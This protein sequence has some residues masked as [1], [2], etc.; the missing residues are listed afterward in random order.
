MAIDAVT[1]YLFQF[2]E[3]SN[4]I[5][6]RYFGKTRPQIRFDFHVPEFISDIARSMDLSGGEKSVPVRAKMQILTIM[7]SIHNFISGEDF[8]RPMLGLEKDAYRAR[9]KETLKSI[10]IPAFNGA[11]RRDE[12]LNESKDLGNT[13]RSPIFPGGFGAWM[14]NLDIP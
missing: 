9:V 11:A 10:L 12:R 2:P 13:V 5:L 7:N 3:I 8:F 1:E 14:F 6:L 4:L